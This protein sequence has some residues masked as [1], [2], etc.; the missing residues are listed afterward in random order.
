MAC[1]VLHVGAYSDNEDIGLMVWLWM[2]P[3]LEKVLEQQRVPILVLSAIADPAASQLPE[4][5]LYAYL[6]S[7]PA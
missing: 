6:Y 3:V 5:L 1:T 4:S 2:G 7:V